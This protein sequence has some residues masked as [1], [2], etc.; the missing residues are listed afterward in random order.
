MK[1]IVIVTRRMVM[2]GIEKSLISLLKE[3]SKDKYDVTVLVMG[4]GGELLEKIP[5]HVN[6]QCLYGNEKTTIEKIKK[7]IIKGKLLNALKIAWYTFLSKKTN[8]VFEQEMYH[9]KMLPVITDDF[10][11]AIAYHTPAS[12]PVVYVMNN[13]IAKKKVA[14]IHS[15]V[16]QYKEALKRYKEFYLNYDRIF[17]VSNYALEKFNELFPELKNKSSVFYNIL[18]KKLIENEAL[19]E[20]GFND[21]FNGIRILTVGRLTLEKGLNLLPLVSLKLKSEGINFRWYWIGDG[22]LRADLE[23]MIKEN[24]LEDH[25]YLLGTQFNP[26]TFI[27]QCDFYVQPSLHEGYCITLAEARALSKPII[28]TDTIGAR[29]QIKSGENGIIVNHHEEELYLAIK[30]LIIDKKLCTKFRSELSN[31]YINTS[32]EINKLVECIG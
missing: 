11:L 28:T 19:K 29:E 18:D 17:C 23:N 25:I 22:E 27:K 4:K 26:Y 32:S 2:G 24:K 13:I 12:L 31:E 20:G 8:S 5:S 14:W 21:S 6:V 16:S 3:L 1:K 7:Y 9:T 15:D 10:D 30:N